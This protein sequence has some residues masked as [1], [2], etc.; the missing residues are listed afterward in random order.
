MIWFYW[1]SCFIYLSLFIFYLKNHFVVVYFWFNLFYYR[2]F[3]PYGYVLFKFIFRSWFYL[4]YLVYQGSLNFIIYF[5]FPIL[6]ELMVYFSYCFISI[7]NGLLVVKCYSSLMVSGFPR[8]EFNSC[9]LFNFYFLFIYFY[10]VLRF[11]GISSYFYFYNFYIYLVLWI[12]WWFSI[13]LC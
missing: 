11:R 6:K 9:S 1:L 2:L 10:L 8:N 7:N 3:V 4:L 12:L 13:W 5:Y